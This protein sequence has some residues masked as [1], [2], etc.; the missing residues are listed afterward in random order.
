MYICL[1][2]PIRNV[3][4]KSNKSFTKIFISKLTIRIPFGHASS[5][6]GFNFFFLR[7]DSE[8]LLWH[9]IVLAPKEAG[10][11]LD[12]NEDRHQC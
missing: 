12:I 9:D 2:D 11:S 4:S 8:G 1:D 5:S 3:S 7:R 10:M 6:S